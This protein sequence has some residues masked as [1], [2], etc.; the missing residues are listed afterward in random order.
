LDRRNIKLKPS[1]TGNQASVMQDIS[2][3]VICSNLGDSF[4][5]LGWINFIM[6]ILSFVIGLIDREVSVYWQLLTYNK[7]KNLSKEFGFVL[8]HLLQH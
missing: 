8:G 5:Y 1:T 4:V 2:T 7:V 3:R 6:C